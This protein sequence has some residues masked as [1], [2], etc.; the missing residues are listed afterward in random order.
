MLYKLTN[1]SKCFINLIKI[2]LK[3]SKDNAPKL[4]PKPKPAPLLGP[5]PGQAS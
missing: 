2:F 5:A 3:K 4:V 1:I